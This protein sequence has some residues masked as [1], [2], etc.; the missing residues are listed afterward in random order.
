[1]K[2]KIAGVAVGLALLGAIG[3]AEAAVITPAFEFTSGIGIAS[4]GSFTIG[5]MFSLSSAVTVNALGYIN[6]GTRN[7]YEVGIWNSS[8]ALIA[9]TTVLNSDPQ[10]GHFRYDTIANLSLGAGTYTIGGEYIDG[11]GGVVPVLLSGVTSISQYTWL[12]DEQVSGSGLNQPTLSSGI[13]GQNGIAAVDF[14]VA[15]AATPL[16]STWTMLLLGLAGL[17]FFAY[18]GAKNRSAALAAA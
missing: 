7:S 10:V 14:S 15:T 11:S 18:G 8:N 4:S 16:P 3:S 5:Y 12:K 13:F 17:G 1:M 2:S 9:S 6:D